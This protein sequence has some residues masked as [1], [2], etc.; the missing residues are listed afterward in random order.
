MRKQH[1]SPRKYCTP[2]MFT[3]FVCALLSFCAREF[4][5]KP[6]T[7]EPRKFI[8]ERT[9]YASTSYEIMDPMRAKQVP[10][11]VNFIRY[12]RSKKSWVQNFVQFI[13]DN[14]TEQRF[15]NYWSPHLSVQD[16]L[17]G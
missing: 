11:E 13:M 5:A 14:E 7:L 3:H 17:N 15:L 2:V 16:A 9:S 6:E 10:L 8:V 12:H 1:Q 4:P